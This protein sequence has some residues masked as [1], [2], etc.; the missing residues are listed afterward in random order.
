MADEATVA[1]I[2]QANT[3][4]MTCS[5]GAVMVASLWG[6]RQPS[7]HAWKKNQPAV[8]H[9]WTTTNLPDKHSGTF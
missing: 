7:A 8:P 4:S 6:S 1:V 5:L 9:R 3:P 2:A